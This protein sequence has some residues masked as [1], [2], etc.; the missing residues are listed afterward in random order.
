MQTNHVHWRALTNPNYLGAYSLADGKDLILTINAV[1]QEKVIGTDG[2]SDECTVIYF[3]DSE[4]PMIANVTNLRMIA[5]VIGS[6]FVDEWA[7]HKIQIG[8]EKVRAFGDVVE[9]LRVRKFA[10]KA[11]M[12]MCEKCGN[13]IVPAHGMNAEQLAQYTAK[14]YGAKLCAD[15]AAEVAKGN[16]D[17]AENSTVKE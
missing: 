6:P 5:K 7:G 9:A 16:A 4:K 8:V 1:K 14:K 12:I 15:C 10:P 11:V 13:N 17:N 2:K 3:S